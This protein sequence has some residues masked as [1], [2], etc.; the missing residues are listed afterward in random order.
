MKL[1]KI[2]CT[3]VS[4]V[5]IMSVSAISVNAAYDPYRDGTDITF[6]STSDM[7]QYMTDN[8]TWSPSDAYTI[9]FG[10]PAANE[11]FVVDTDIDLSEYTSALAMRA[12]VVVESGCTLDIRNSQLFIETSGLDLTNNGTIYCKQIYSYGPTAENSQ[13]ITNNGKMYF[14]KFDSESEYDNY[15]ITYENN[16]NEF[17]LCNNGMIFLN[18][19]NLIKQGAGTVKLGSGTG[20]ILTTDGKLTYSNSYHDGEIFEHGNVPLESGIN[21]W[22]GQIGNIGTYVTEE[23]EKGNSD[24]TMNGSAISA[25]TY[26][27]TIP[28]TVSFGTQQKTAASNIVVTPAT[29]SASGVS[30]LFANQQKL[31]VTVESKNNFVVTDNI[32]TSSNV[33]YDFYTS[34]DDKTKLGTDKTVLTMVGTSTADKDLSATKECT[35]ALDTKDISKAGNFSDT[36]TFTIALESVGD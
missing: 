29:I 7:L 8:P 16:E 20:I 28:K 25:P 24:I 11:P 22:Q 36:M 23:T 13:I 19:Y 18:G 15:A 26:T 5:M 3:A 2:L 27:V 4:T 17:E 21:V 6:Y 10:E 30:N 34:Y 14:T 1:K 31:V 35:L 33:P 32:L 9:A 12:N